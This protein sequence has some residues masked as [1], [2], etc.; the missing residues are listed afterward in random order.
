MET[1]IGEVR[2][3]KIL[4]DISKT[5]ELRVLLRVVWNNKTNEAAFNPA[6]DMKMGDEIKIAIFKV[7]GAPKTDVDKNVSAEQWD[8][9]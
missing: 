3:K 2:G 5:D 4:K 6:E 9:V 7:S 8:S 1:K